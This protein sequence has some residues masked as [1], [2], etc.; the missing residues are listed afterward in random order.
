MIAIYLCMR[1]GVEQQQQLNGVMEN[2]ELRRRSVG[3][4]LASPIAPESGVN[5]Q[6]QAES[7]LINN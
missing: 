7:Y 6:Y 5:F 2:G 4:D 1:C 3:V